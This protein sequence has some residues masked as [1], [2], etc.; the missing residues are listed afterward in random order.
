MV[1][2]LDTEVE[3]GTGQP[4]RKMGSP[5]MQIP[6]LELV[7]LIAVEVVE[8]EAGLPSGSTRK[9]SSV[10]FRRVSESADDSR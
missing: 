1:L 6:V 3:V 2:E 7:E 8:G 9:D 4:P 10:V 5:G